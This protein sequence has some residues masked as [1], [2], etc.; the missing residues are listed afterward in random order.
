MRAPLAL[1]FTFLALACDAPAPAIM[2]VAFPHPQTTDTVGPYRVTAVT[3]GV[4]TGAAI[5]W[6]VDLI[7]G[8]APEPLESVAMSLTNEDHWV[9]H[10]PGAH[11]GAVVTL[12]VEVV[13]PGGRA[14]TATETFLVL[15]PDGACRVD[16]ECP[17]GTLC[18]R[19]EGRCHRP[20]EACGDDGDCPQDYVCVEGACRLRGDGCVDDEACESGQV[21]RSGQCVPTPECEAD[22]DCPDGVCVPP[23]RCV[24]EVECAPGD[25]D[26]ADPPCGADDYEPNDVPTAEALGTISVRSPVMGSLCPTDVDH[27]VF[28]PPGERIVINADGRIQAETLGPRGQV[29]DRATGGPNGAVVLG[30]PPAGGFLRLQTEVERVDYRAEVPGPPPSRC[31]E[32]VFE[33]N[34]DRGEATILG[35]NGADLQGRIC[36]D[37]SDW[38]RLRRR[39]E[40]AAGR[41]SLVP[42]DE[43][44]LHWEMRGSGAQILAQGSVSAPFDFDYPG[45][46]ETLYFVVTCGQCRGD[47]RYR[48]ATAMSMMECAEDAL[49]PNHD[50]EGGVSIPTDAEI[51]DLVACAGA[52]D[53]FEFEKDEDA[54]I[55]I[56]ITYAEFGGDLT[57]E[58]IA[59]FGRFRLEAVGED[60]VVALTVPR[61]ANGGAYLL[62]VG[63]IG[64]GSNAYELRIEAR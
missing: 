16:S 36:A 25:P 6:G 29:I 23:G 56:E 19:I 53:F 7:S 49:A 58:V 18:D 43:A 44:E 32:D 38:Y 41:V 51:V 21:C 34:N 33:P 20:P 4:A 54:E 12:Y 8:P 48:V 52:D 22:A 3:A 30:A 61:R 63:L 55:H 9:G 45:V 60:G 17:T 2:E 39:P 57:A 47:V 24:D 42:L 40:D 13:G 59:R 62:R 26:C 37:D 35:G 50:P 64:S 14:R 5:H 28:F 1:A 10:I 46:E 31:G 15:A 11:A 27:F